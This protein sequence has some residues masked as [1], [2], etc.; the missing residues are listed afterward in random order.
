MKKKR[1]TRSNL[2]DSQEVKKCK[3]AK[4]KRKKWVEV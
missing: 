3:V 2:I 4:D 1:S